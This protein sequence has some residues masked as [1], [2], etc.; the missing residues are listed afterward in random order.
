MGQTPTR[1]NATECREF[2]KYVGY[3]LNRCAFCLKASAEENATQIVDQTGS[4]FLGH[5][6][7]LDVRLRWNTKNGHS[8]KHGLFH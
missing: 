8:S 3:G 2:K 1:K 5:P 7:F 6:D 4:S